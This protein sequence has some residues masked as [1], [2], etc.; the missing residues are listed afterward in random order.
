[1]HVVVQQSERKR[2]VVH[3]MMGNLDI[4]HLQ[5]LEEVADQ[6]EEILQK[7]VKV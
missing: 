5:G 7:F 3:M 4:P 1:M 6:M 2:E